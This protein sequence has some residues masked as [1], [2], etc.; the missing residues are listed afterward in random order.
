MGFGLNYTNTS[1]KIKKIHINNTLL[2]DEIEDNLR[3]NSLKLLKTALISAK[4][5]DFISDYLDV[6]EEKLWGKTQY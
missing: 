5:R 2:I 3:V 1:M 6:L 4:K